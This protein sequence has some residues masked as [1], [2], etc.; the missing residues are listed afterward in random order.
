[1]KYSEPINFRAEPDLAERLRQEAEQSGASV[2]ALIRE[3]LNGQ[4]PGFQQQYAQAREA[5]SEPGR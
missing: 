4:R 5:V 3:K 1:M 2:S